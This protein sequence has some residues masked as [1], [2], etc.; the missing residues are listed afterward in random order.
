MSPTELVYPLILVFVGNNPLVKLQLVL[1]NLL[2]IHLL[3]C[4]GLHFR[5]YAVNLR[6]SS[7][8]SVVFFDGIHHFHVIY[9]LVYIGFTFYVVGP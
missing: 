5:F 4:V 1:P 7:L 2:K 9:F 6:L 8:H 3:L